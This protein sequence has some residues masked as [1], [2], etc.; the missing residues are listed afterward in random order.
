MPIYEYLCPQCGTFTA[1]RPVSEFDQPAACAG[2][3][4]PAPRQRSL[5]VLLRSAGAGPAPRT[6]PA[7]G[8]Y[9]R[10]RHVGCN[11]C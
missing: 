4:E 2:C 1:R 6:Q 7:G 10:M 5:P 8:G 3:G 9:P 11:C